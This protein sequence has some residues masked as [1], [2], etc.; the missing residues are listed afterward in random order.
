M[1]LSCLM[2]AKYTHSVLGFYNDALWCL[3]AKI[4]GRKLIEMEGRVNLG[5]KSENGGEMSGKVWGF[6]GLKS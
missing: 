6:E 4:V 1:L 5:L 2:W 3:C